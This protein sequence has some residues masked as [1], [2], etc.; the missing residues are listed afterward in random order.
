M[1]DEPKTPLERFVAHGDTVLKVVAVLFAVDVV[2]LLVSLSHKFHDER[3]E[4]IVLIAAAAVVGFAV[5]RVRSLA[6]FSRRG[7]G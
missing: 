1:E 4:T 3:M 5:G 7:G 6:W 2:V